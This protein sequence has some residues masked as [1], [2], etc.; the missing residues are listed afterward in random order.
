[1]GT[2]GKAE[3]DKGGKGQVTG[4]IGHQGDLSKQVRFQLRPEG[5]TGRRPF[6]REGK[7]GTKALRQEPGQVLEVREG[8]SCSWKRQPGAIEMERW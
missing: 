4:S 6:Q 2:K 8:D 5:G 1:M 7:A 3:Q